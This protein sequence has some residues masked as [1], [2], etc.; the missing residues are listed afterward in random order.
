MG[1]SVIVHAPGTDDNYYFLPIYR[2][3]MVTTKTLHPHVSCNK[4]PKNYKNVGLIYCYRFLFIANSRGFAV[5]IFNDF[6]RF[7]VE[8]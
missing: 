3:I 4:L 8:S 1:F 6:S 7:F 5:K 2:C